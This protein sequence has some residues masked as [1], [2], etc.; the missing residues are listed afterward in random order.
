MVIKKNVLGQVLYNAGWFAD[1]GTIGLEG[2]DTGLMLDEIQ[3]SCYDTN[4]E[5]EEFQQKFRVGTLL[6]ITTTVEIKLSSKTDRDLDELDRANDE[7]QRRF[8]LGEI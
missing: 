5:E 3:I 7:I 1:I 2:M 4:D 8:E 6:D